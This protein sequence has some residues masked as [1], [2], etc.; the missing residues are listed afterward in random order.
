MSK[1][2]LHQILPTL[3]AASIINFLQAKLKQ[4]KSPL[5]PR[6]PQQHCRLYGYKA[7]P[8]VLLMCS[9]GTNMRIEHWWN[10]TENTKLNYSKNTL[11]Q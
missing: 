3:R 10:Y 1:G 9:V 2:T 8:I 11:S 5:L 7:R 4:R 6:Y